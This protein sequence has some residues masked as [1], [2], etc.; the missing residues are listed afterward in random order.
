MPNMSYCRFQNTW[1]DL[2]DCYDA[3]TGIDEYYQSRADLSR[4]EFESLKQLIQACKD[5]V[6]AE[7]CDE[8][9]L[10]HDGEKVD[11]CDIEDDDDT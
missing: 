7:E 6:E 8:I 2:R 11:A 3:M 9:V 10:L 1:L 4:E 5:V